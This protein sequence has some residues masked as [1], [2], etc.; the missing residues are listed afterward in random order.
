MILNDT[1]IIRVW[2]VHEKQIGP[3]TRFYVHNFG[4]PRPDSIYRQTTLDYQCTHTVIWKHRL[5][6]KYFAKYMLQIGY[7]TY[8]TTD[9]K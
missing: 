2:T 9:G 8:C 3:S 7:L 5:D 4:R 1:A 6:Y